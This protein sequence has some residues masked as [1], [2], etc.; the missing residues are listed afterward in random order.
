MNRFHDS[1]KIFPRCK[2]GDQ[3]SV[4]F[5]YEEELAVFKKLL[6]R[7]GKIEEP[8]FEF[9]FITTLEREVA[10]DYCRP[11]MKILGYR[12]MAIDKKAHIIREGCYPKETS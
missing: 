12:I 10:S 5:Q 2:G 8:E 11:L 6:G 1:V 7:L 3:I 4:E 9:E